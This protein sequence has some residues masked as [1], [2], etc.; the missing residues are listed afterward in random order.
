MHAGIG[1]V[2]DRE[3]IFTSHTSVGCHCRRNNFA[4]ASCMH[5]LGCNKVFIANT[6]YYLRLEDKKKIDNLLIQ[7]PTSCAIKGRQCLG[8]HKRLP[9]VAKMKVFE[10]EAGSGVRSCYGKSTL[11]SSRCSDLFSGP[12]ATSKYLSWEKLHSW[13]RMTPSNFKFRHAP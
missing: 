6:K 3:G 9:S 12:K 2:T 11:K 8:P 7:Y 1:E 5:R 4:F 10:V 13:S